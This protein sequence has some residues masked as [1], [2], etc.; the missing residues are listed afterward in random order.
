MEKNGS[1]LRLGPAGD[2]GHD[3]LRYELR[4][5]LGGFGWEGGDLDR[6]VEGCL[7]AATACDM[8]AQK[9]ETPLT[10]VEARLEDWSRRIF[11]DDP[12]DGASPLLL[13]R[14]AFRACDGPRQWPHCFLGDDLPEAFV[15]AMQAAAPEPTPPE[16]EGAMPDQTFEFWGAA[17]LAPAE[18][19]TGR[20][21][22]V[23]RATAP[24]LARPAD[25]RAQ[26]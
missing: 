10:L 23:Q 15:L 1:P 22:V 7:P 24:A 21:P 11:G 18:W 3:A 20:V 16:D 17:G 13:A 12:A 6:L 19:L 5:Y 14:A 26:P 8:S 2:A 25:R 4:T 9:G